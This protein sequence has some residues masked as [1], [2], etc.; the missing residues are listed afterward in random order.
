MFKKNLKKSSFDNSYHLEL[1]NKDIVHIYPETIKA[2]SKYAGSKNGT[3][4]RVNLQGNKLTSIPE[5]IGSL[6]NL[7]KLDLY[8]NQLKALPEAIGKLKNLKE[9]DLCA[10]QLQALPKS[11]GNLKNLDRLIL[12]GNNV[13]SEKI[14]A[15]QK[16]CH[17]QKS[18][19]VDSML[20]FYF[21]CVDFQRILIS[22]FR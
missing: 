10:N 5:S 8:K 2:I 6:T 12:S 20:G 3:I 16:N 15:L 11:I 4:T 18:F 13:G 22:G 1:A 21:L 7:Y 19:W 14:N 17:K 9:L